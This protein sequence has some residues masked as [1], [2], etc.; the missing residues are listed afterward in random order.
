[1]SRKKLNVTEA[2]LVTEFSVWNVTSHY[3]ET[4]II[5]YRAEASEEE[6]KIFLSQRGEAVQKDFKNS[7]VKFWFDSIKFV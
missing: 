4:D 6:Y 3:Y 1:M 7:H 5:P 2:D